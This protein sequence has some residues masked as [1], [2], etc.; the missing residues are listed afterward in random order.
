M[1]NVS[2]SNNPD[3]TILIFDGDIRNF[4]EMAWEIISYA[5]LHGFEYKE[6]DPEDEYYFEKLHA[7]A[8]DAIEFLND[9]IAEEGKYFYWDI[10]FFYGPEDTEWM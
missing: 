3:E 5:N 9:N 4:E 6:L 7:T 1:A 8:E 2:K 10:H